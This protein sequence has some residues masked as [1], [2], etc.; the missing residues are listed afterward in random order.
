MPASQLCQRPV[1]NGF[2]LIELLAVILI[3]GL[4]V[5]LV[6]FSGNGDNSDYKLR[7]ELR[8]FANTLGLLTEEASLAGEQ[9]GVDFYWDIVDGQE[10][11]GYRWLKLEVERPESGPGAVSAMEAVPLEEI[12]VAEKLDST[13]IPEEQW[14]PYIPEDF[15]A[16][17]LFP[18]TYVLQVEVDGSELEITEKLIPEQTGVL[19]AEQLVPDVWLFSSGE[20]TPFV[21][22]L[23]DRETPEKRQQVIIDMLG[24]MSLESEEQ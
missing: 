15:A 9:Y 24:R 4:A 19:D 12:A 11:Y 10:V 18:P 20:V 7:E 3:I 16:E 1:A 8:F 2:S 6:S 5:G 14:Q 21:L 13:A 17:K 22:T 23:L